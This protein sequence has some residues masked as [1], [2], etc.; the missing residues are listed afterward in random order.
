[1]MRADTKQNNK[2]S[3]GSRE[4]K[5]RFSSYYLGGVDISPTRGAKQISNNRV[6]PYKS[7]E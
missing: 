5:V 2:E 3:G 4:K 1:M 7:E 6:H